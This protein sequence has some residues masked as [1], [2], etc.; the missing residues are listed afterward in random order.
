M[1]TI[2]ITGGAG[3]V[4]RH[5]C[6]RFTDLKC[7]VL[8]IDNLMSE[9]SLLPQY[10]PEHLK[11]DNQYFKFIN[12]DCREYFKSENQEQFNLI[13]QCSQAKHI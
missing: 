5:I 4:G 12:M 11:C 13:I 10:W 7:N 8:C 3:F 6:K 9:S 2:L 1:K